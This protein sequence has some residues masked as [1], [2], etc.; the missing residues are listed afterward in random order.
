MDDEQE[1]SLAVLLFDRKKQRDRAAVRSRL[2][3]TAIA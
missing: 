1:R 3:Q 2:G